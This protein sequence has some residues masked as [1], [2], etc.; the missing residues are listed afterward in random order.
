MVSNTA[1]ESVRAAVQKLANSAVI[2]M[3]NVAIDCWCLA[4]GVVVA[5]ECIVCSLV[6]VVVVVVRLFVCDKPPF[7]SDPC[8]LLFALT[9]GCP[10]PRLIAGWCLVFGVVVVVVVCIVCSFVRCCL[11]VCDKPP[12]QS[13][14]IRSDL[15]V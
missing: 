3:G 11:F 5:V 6:F 13:D 15:C 10:G 2:G 4:F 8:V 14:P 7:R 9:V 12:F 1:T